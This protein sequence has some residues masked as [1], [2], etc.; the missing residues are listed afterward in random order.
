MKLFSK[1][2]AVLMVV[3]MLSV[4]AFAAEFTL[5]AEIKDGPE[6]IGDDVV[7]TPI[8]KIDDPTTPPQTKEELKDAKDQLDNNKFEDLVPGFNDEW[9]EITGGA[10]VDNATVSDLIHVDLKDD[11]ADFGVNFDGID[12]DTKFVLVGLNHETGKWGIVDYTMKDGVINLKLDANTSIAVVID[13]GNPPAPGGDSPQTGASSFS[14]A[15]ATVTVALCGAAFV[16][17][18]KIR[19]EA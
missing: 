16:L 11:S 13:N 12:D 1:I 15:L 2:L 17:S 14:V 19:Y 18:R 9:K 4:S 5:S 3:A 10:P 8:S 6:V 7:I